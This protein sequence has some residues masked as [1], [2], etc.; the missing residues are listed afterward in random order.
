M[1]H[2]Y[3]GDP[4]STSDAFTE[5]GYFKTGDLGYATGPRTFVFQTRLSDTL[6]L[7]GVQV[8]PAEIE[9]HLCTHSDVIGAQVVEVRQ[10][11]TSR[12]FAFI[13]P[14]Q[15]SVDL[16]SLRGHCVNSLAPF[17]VPIGFQVLSE[18][19]TTK[20]ANG[21]KIQRVKLRQMAEAALKKTQ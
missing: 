6:R 13:V 9:S 20:S 12:A 17:K 21:T 16:D 19:P 14:A 5:D 18:F 1:M 10:G 2:E 11:D 15:P 4:E 8:N 3:L 7:T